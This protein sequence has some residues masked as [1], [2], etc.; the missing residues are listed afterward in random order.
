[1]NPF[2]D[3]AETDAE[4]RELVSHAQGGSR[5]ALERLHCFPENSIWNESVFSVTRLVA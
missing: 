3:R 1:M 4:D 5:D 2:S